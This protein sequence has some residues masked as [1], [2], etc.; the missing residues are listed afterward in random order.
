MTKFSMAYF[1]VIQSFG[2]Y[3]KLRFGNWKLPRSGLE[4]LVVSH[5]QLSFDLF[6]CF[7]DN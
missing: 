5:Y 6:D 1:L 4:S 3:W 2:F 7:N